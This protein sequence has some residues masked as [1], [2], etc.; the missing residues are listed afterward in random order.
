MGYVGGER[1]EDVRSVD[2]WWEGGWEGWRGKR[3]ALGRL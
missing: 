3:D 2:L 1:G